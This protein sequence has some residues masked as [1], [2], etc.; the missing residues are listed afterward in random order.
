MTNS[1]QVRINRES[2]LDKG[3]IGRLSV[4][5]F[6]FLNI[7]EDDEVEERLWLR[8]SKRNAKEFFGII[9]N[10]PYAL[11][12]V[13]LGDEI[14]FGEEHIFNFSNLE[15]QQKIIKEFE[16]KGEVDT[17]DNFDGDIAQTIGEIL[18]LAANKKQNRLGIY[19]ISKNEIKFFSEIPKEK[20]ELWRMF[21]S[22]VLIVVLPQIHEYFDSEDRVFGLSRDYFGQL[23]AVL[24]KAKKIYRKIAL[25][26][27]SMISQMR[28]FYVND[29]LDKIEDDDLPELFERFIDETIIELETK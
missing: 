15:E 24:K 9:I 28:A 7:A 29:E 18:D 2:E 5:D 8:I 26:K 21:L 14:K 27:G 12:Q 20:T 11:K 6:V 16:K 17:G 25:R 13:R 22:L 19:K 10:K 3:A 23:S 1:W 4:D